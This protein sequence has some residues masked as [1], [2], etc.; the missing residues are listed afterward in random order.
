MQRSR[1]V[2]SRAL[3]PLASY[4]LDSETFITATR[5]GPDA[6]ERREIQDIERKSYVA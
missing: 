1:A 3:F 4:K 6:R 2:S 5:E